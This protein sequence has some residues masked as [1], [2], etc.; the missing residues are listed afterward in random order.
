MADGRIPVLAHLGGHGDAMLPGLT[1]AVPDAEFVE[2]TPGAAPAVPADVLVTLLNDRPALGPVLASGVRW[3]HVLGAGIDGF[4]LEQL[5]DQLLTC[6]RGASAPAIAEFVIASML[7]FEKHIPDV[8]IHEP[9]ARWNVANL[10]G[11]KGR[12]LGLIGIGAIGT[13][14]ARRAA[15]FDMRLIAARRDAAKPAPFGVEIRPLDEVLAR[16]DHLVVTAASTPATRHLID[17][18]ALS[19]AKAGVHLVNIARG[20][21]VDQDALMD[22]LESGTVAAASLDVVDPEPL[23]AGHPLYTHP[24]VR[25]TAHISWSSPDTGRRTVEIFAE[26][27][28]RWRDGAPLEGVVDVES[29]Y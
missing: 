2:V 28:R 9:P 10:G 20:A 4:P 6:S 23:P 27:F 15:A 25:L 14:V 22:A 19:T 5:S 16:A 7:A 3:V 29:G 8:W 21:L 12:T 17:R 18:R 11:L 24:R 26:N 13:E 1:A